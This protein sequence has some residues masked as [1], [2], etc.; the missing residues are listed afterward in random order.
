VD[1]NTYAFMTDDYTIWQTRDGRLVPVTEMTDSHLLNT[2]RAIREGR[3]LA[4]P[5]VPRNKNTGEGNE[6]M[7]MVAAVRAQ[8]RR[9]WLESLLAEVKRRGL[10]D[11]A[12]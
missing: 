6:G 11:P 7:A 4:V 12:A 2:V 1:N 8:R 10:A 5:D 3:V 9:R